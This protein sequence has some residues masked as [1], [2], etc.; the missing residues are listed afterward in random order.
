MNKSILGESPLLLDKLV[1]A[2]EFDIHYEFL[3]AENLTKEYF[4]FGHKVVET[5]ESLQ[6]YQ[7]RV[8]KRFSKDQQGYGEFVHSLFDDFLKSKGIGAR[9]TE[10]LGNYFGKRSRDAKYVADIYRQFIKVLDA[11]QP[12]PAPGPKTQ[13]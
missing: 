5:K 2:H 4:V 8:A 13:V 9:Y 1:K 7:D 10:F 6:S 11:P 3:K 12:P